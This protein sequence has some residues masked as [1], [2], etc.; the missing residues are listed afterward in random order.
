MA[1]ITPYSVF[2]VVAFLILIRFLIYLANV[3]YF[4]EY[5]I[6]EAVKESIIG[7]IV[8]SLVVVIMILPVFGVFIFIHIIIANY[9]QITLS[10]PI[11]TIPFLWTAL[12]AIIMFS[13]DFWAE[14]EDGERLAE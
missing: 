11:Y 8:I 5:S 10:H 14:K 2:S 1:N 3:G 6:R 7:S 12:I 4:T 13:V 9:L